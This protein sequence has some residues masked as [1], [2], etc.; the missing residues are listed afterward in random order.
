MVQ[1]GVGARLRRSEWGFLAVFALLERRSSVV[2]AIVWPVCWISGLALGEQ[3]AR[4]AARRARWGGASRGAGPRRAQHASGAVGVH[5]HAA[6]TQ[7]ELCSLPRAAHS[8]ASRLSLAAAARTSFCAATQRAGHHRGRLQSLLILRW[9][10]ALC[11]SCARL[12]AAAIAAYCA[13]HAARAAWLP[14]WLLALPPPTIAIEPIQ[15][16]SI[17][18]S[19]LLVFR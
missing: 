16:T 6:A 11:A 18:L 9:C 15:L 10:C 12:P 2:K 19:L 13:A 14:A 7:V 17:A 8:T 1:E 4:G 5:G 3:G